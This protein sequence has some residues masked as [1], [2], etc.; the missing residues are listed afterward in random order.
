M[1]PM[2]KKDFCHIVTTLLARG[3]VPTLDA[4]FF[5]KSGRLIWKE[6][7]E[8]RIAMLFKSPTHTSAANEQN[9]IRFTS[10]FNTCLMTH[11][12]KLAEKMKVGDKVLDGDAVRT[13]TGFRKV[14]E[15]HSDGS[16][17]DQICQRS[18]VIVLDNDKEVMAYEV[19]TVNLSEP[20]SLPPVE[21][22]YTPLDCCLP[23]DPELHLSF[24]RLVRNPACRYDRDECSHNRNRGRRTHFTIEISNYE[25]RPLAVERDLSGMEKL[26][27]LA[28][29]ENDTCPIYN[30]GISC[31]FWIHP[32]EVT[33]FRQDYKMAKHALPFFL[34]QLASDKATSEKESVESEEREE[35]GLPPEPEDLLPADEDGTLTIDVETVRTVKAAYPTELLVVE[36]QVFVR[37]VQAQ[38]EFD[39][40]YYVSG[41]HEVSPQ[42]REV[43]IRIPFLDW[44]FVRDNMD[45]FETLPRRQVMIAPDQEFEPCCSPLMYEAEILGLVKPSSPVTRC[46]NRG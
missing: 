25:D 46:A 17:K 5:C 30:E 11:S 16:P 41:T 45:A 15:R 28:G 33:K 23:K 3:I 29:W 9:R 8:T 14:V 21:K 32:E 10:W 12:A 40:S 19:S 20:M 27:M 42:S 26:L 22:V 36:D 2:L 24:I 37:A 6:K 34:A 38:T 7:G 31:G 35:S 4:S 1:K 44:N 18:G 43:F 13:I 39:D